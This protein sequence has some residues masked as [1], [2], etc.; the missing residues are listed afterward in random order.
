M[1]HKEESRFKQK[2]IEICKMIPHG[3]VVSYGQVALMAGVP[4][5]AQAVGQVL[6]QLEDTPIKSKHNLPW[7]R[8][9]NNAGRVSIKGTKYHNAVTQKALLVKENIEVKKDL[10]FD[11]EEYRWRPEPELLEKLEL[12]ERYIEKIIEKYLY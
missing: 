12:D 10:T 6:R 9:V 2:I 1:E 7:W 4:K 11:I 5:A 8:V 3:K